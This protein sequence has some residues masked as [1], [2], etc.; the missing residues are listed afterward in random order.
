MGSS[1]IITIHDQVH[2]NMQFRDT[3]MVQKNRVRNNQIPIV[4]VFVISIMA[5]MMMM[6]MIIV[7]K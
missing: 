3:A 4:S 5:M 1:G 6:M 2:L 7:F